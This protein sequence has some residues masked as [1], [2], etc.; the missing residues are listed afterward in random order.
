MA[1]KYPLCAGRAE[2]GVKVIRL[3]LNLAVKRSVLSTKLLGITPEELEGFCTKG[4]DGKYKA[5][6]FC[7]SHF[8]V[9]AP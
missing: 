7:A 6:F 2:N 4:P 5:C 3:T 9:R 8:K 1:C